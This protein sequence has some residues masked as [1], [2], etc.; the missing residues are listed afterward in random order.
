MKLGSRGSLNLEATAGLIESTA[1]KAQTG[2]ETA[3]FFGARIS[4]GA[5]TPSRTQP[6]GIG[7]SYVL[8]SMEDEEGP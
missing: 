2:D 1:A 8:G 5:Q 7:E 4:F 6:I 3:I